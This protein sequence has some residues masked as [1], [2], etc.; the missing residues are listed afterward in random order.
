M[1][2]TAKFEASWHYAWGDLCV[3]WWVAATRVWAARFAGH[4]VAKARGPRG[5]AQSPK[6]RRRC[7]RAKAGIRGTTFSKKSRSKHVISMACAR[8][9]PVHCSSRVRLGESLVN[10]RCERSGE[11]FSTETA[12]NSAFGSVER[13]FLE[14]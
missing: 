3:F 1:L 8:L 2:F 10:P 13:R 6:A 12:E 5:T 14:R 11:I 4:G 9:N 7:A